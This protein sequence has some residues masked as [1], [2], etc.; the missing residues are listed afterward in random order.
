M[1]LE[2]FE[3]RIKLYEK[4]V[5]ISLSKH[6]RYQNYQVITGIIIACILAFTII[7]FLDPL[8]FKLFKIR[9]GI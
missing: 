4:K 2:K 1:V 6:K 3:K 8:W 5:D 9:V 7:I